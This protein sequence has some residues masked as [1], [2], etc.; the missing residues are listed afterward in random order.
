MGSPRIRQAL[1]AIVGL[2]LS[3][4]AGMNGV[5][6]ESGRAAATSAYGD[7]VNQAVSRMDD[8]KTDPVSMAYGIAPQCAVQ[9]QV[10]SQIMIRENFTE[11]GQI[12]MRQQMRDGELRLVTSAIITH[13]SK[14]R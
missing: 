8:G 10:L 1:P 4:C 6:N 14:R 9:Y 11:N 13:R 12:A 5:P 3:G 2:A 7:C